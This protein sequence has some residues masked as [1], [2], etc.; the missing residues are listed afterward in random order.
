MGLFEIKRPL[1]KEE[2]E[3]YL[4]DLINVVNKALDGNEVLTLDKN[5][6]NKAKRVGPT[7]VTSL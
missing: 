3:D 7:H 1:D 4:S 2:M 6:L 5:R